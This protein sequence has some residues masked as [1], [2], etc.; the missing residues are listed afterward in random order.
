MSEIIY[1]MNSRY[2]VPGYGYQIA[3]GATALPETWDARTDHSHNHLMLGHLQEWFYTQVG[4]IQHD[5]ESPAYKHFI[6]KPSVI[7]E[8]T[9]AR[10]S[11]E[12]PYGTISTDWKITPGGFRMKG[13][14]PGQHDR[15]DMDSG[16]SGRRRNRIGC[17]CRP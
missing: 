16:S 11:F 2:D 17:L 4:G 1:A 13:R 12:S 5:P 7:G 3:Q 6:V 14:G 9:F 8:I 10:T 15:S